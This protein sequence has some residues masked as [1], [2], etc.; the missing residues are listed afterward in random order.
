[1]QYFYKE[2][3]KPI[4]YVQI[5]QHSNEDSCQRLVSGTTE[6]LLTDSVNCAVKLLEPYVATRGAMGSL[7]SIE[8]NHLNKNVI[9]VGTA[10]TNS[11]TI[12]G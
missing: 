11:G 10:T 8:T 5:F 3:T 7:A 12:A 6:F 4:P 2:P 9:M 1:M